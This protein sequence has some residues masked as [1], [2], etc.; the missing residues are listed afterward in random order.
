[1]K[2]ILLA[3]A[4]ITGLVATAPGLQAG[5]GHNPNHKPK[6]TTT[7]SSSTTTTTTTAP[8]P[9]TTTTT[10]PPSCS[11]GTPINVTT[12]GTYNGCYRSTDPAV[13]AVRISTTAPVELDHAR[14]EHTG[15]GVYAFWDFQADLNIHDT[16]F[17]QLDP[18]SGG[19]KRAV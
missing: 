14:I 15:I 3:L 9:T 7:T 5:A 19:S 16:T 6:P 18:G 10:L 11:P 12:G 8:P 17:Q 13:P 1:M 2:R 4:L